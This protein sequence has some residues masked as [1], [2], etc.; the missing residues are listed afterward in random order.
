MRTSWVQRREET[1]VMEPKWYMVYNKQRVR[2]IRIIYRLRT[3][4]YGFAET[5]K[6][7]KILD[8][9]EVLCTCL[10]AYDSDMHVI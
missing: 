9:N 7:R 3:M 5:L 6:I 2:E 4:T 8:A 1:I 10:E